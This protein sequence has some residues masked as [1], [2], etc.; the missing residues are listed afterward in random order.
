MQEQRRESEV[1][2]A[3]KKEGYA[4]DSLHDAST[5]IN[6]KV[7]WIQKGR[8]RYIIGDVEFNAALY[9]GILTNTGARGGA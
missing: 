8:E 4:S 9:Y 2:M 7:F 5:F 3:I 1:T 6:T